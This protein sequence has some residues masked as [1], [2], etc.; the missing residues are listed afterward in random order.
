MTPVISAHTAVRTSTREQT[1]ACEEAGLPATQTPE[2]QPA[3]GC[4]QALSRPRQAVLG[5]KR[6]RGPHRHVPICLH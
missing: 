3:P 6:G 4:G 2:G 5:T 1:D